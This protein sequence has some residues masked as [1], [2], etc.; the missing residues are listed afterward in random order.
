MDMHMAL[1]LTTL[2]GLSTGLGGLVVWL[3]R[4]PGPRIMALSQG[5]CRWGNDDGVAF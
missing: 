1:L 4:T 2:A 3:M 5:V